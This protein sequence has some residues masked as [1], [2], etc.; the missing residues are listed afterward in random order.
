MGAAHRM[1][2]IHLNRELWWIIVEK[3]VI[4][5]ANEMG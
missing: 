2:H 4:L 3:L 5:I 1:I